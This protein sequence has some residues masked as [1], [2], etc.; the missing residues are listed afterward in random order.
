MIDSYFGIRP[1]L[2]QEP[3][4]GDLKLEEAS[5]S[6]ICGPLLASLVRFTS[7]AHL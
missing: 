5:N 3:S 1:A 2:V 4:L 6:G 7:K